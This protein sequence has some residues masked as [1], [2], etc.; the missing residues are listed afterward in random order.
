MASNSETSTHWQGKIVVITGAASG[1][2]QALATALIHKGATV[3]LADRNQG[4]LNDLLGNLGPSAHSLCFNVSEFDAFEKA[5]QQVIRQHGRIDYLFN[6]AGIGFG[7]DASALTHEH[8]DRMI[9][10]NIRGV[11]N[12]VSIAYP[13]MIKQGYGTIVNTASVGG[14]VPSAIMTP[15]AMTKYAVVG[16]SESLR[17]EAATKGV[18]IIT[19]CPGAVNTPIFDATGPADLPR[20]KASNLREFTRES[21]MSCSPAQF[22]EW[23]LRDIE[24][25]KSLIIYPRIMRVAVWLYRHFPAL[26]LKITQPNLSQELKKLNTEP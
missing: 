18:Q 20:F 3:W 9:D 7:C 25:N 24:K 5:V 19:L 21:M 14:L 4:A 6:N 16:L 22:A 2:G 13:L 11:S 10:V 17:L 15:Y 8:Y 12:G 26:Y 1:I 23:A